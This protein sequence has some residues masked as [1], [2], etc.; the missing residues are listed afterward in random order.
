[1]IT[2]EKAVEILKSVEDPELH[3]DIHTLGLI[4][5]LEVKD[6]NVFIQMTF[7]SPMCPFGPKIMEEVS[8]KFKQA[9]A[10]VKIEL[11]FDPVWEPSQE[12]REML[13]V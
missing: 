5:K 6:N 3:I 9:G 11:T 1:M 12:L 4:Y 10:E 7:T 13:G 8:T 2:E